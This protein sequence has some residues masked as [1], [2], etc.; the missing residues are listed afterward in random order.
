MTTYNLALR[1]IQSL[2]GS[3]NIN[4][5]ANTVTLSDNFAVTINTAT[6]VGVNIVSI[7]YGPNFAF[8]GL[9]ALT[10]TI[11][12]TSNTNTVVISQFSTD[13]TLT[14]NNTPGSF[15]LIKNG[16]GPNLAIKGVTVGTNTMSISS[17]STAIIL[18]KSNISDVT[19]NSVV[20][21]NTNIIINGKGPNLTL[22]SLVGT[23][24]TTVTK[25]NNVT[26]VS[27][28]A[29]DVFLNTTGSATNS[30]VYVNQ[31]PVLKLHAFVVSPAFGLTENNGTVNIDGSMPYLRCSLTSYGIFSQGWRYALLDQTTSLFANNRFILNTPVNA[32]IPGNASIIQLPG[33]W[34]MVTIYFFVNITNTGD[35]VDSVIYIAIITYPSAGGYAQ[36]DSFK[37]DLLGGNQGTFYPSGF[38][39]YRTLTHTFFVPG[40]IFS[41]GFTGTSNNGGTMRGGDGYS[42]AAGA[43]GN[44]TAP[45]QIV[46]T[47]IVVTPW[48]YTM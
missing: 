45:A 27:T 23:G 13:V 38:N 6:S 48:T 1:S 31:G 5:D 12:I 36:A 8:L 4:S 11:S 19:L 32:L 44:I 17:N 46:A 7:G 14:D 40:S 47:H 25:I 35:N 41:I 34:L 37:F 21:A 22:K 18:N 28:A 42:I 26:N 39:T 30:L 20:A 43:G 24:T 2:D 29:T 10:P 3:I 33:A 9:N 16:V 15:S